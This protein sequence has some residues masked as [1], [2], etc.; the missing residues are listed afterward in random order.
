[1]IRLLIFALLPILAGCA[2]VRTAPVEMDV[3]NA[4]GVTYF[5]PK[6]DILMT[7][8]RTPLVKEEVEKSIKKIEG[9]IE[10]AKTEITAQKKLQADAVL[11]LSN[12]AISD[13]D[14]AKYTDQ[15]SFADFVI[16]K[17][18]ADNK[19]REATKAGLAASLAQH[20][21]GTCQYLY[22]VKLE[23]QPAAADTSQRFVANLTHSILRDDEQKFVVTQGGLLSS[24]D[25][26]ATD[27]TGDILVEIAG[28]I[29]AFGGGPVGVIKAA[30]FTEDNAQAVPCELTIKTLRY[31]FDPSAPEKIKAL[32]EVL[33]GGNWPFAV[34]ESGIATPPLWPSSQTTFFAAGD[35]PDGSSGKATRCLKDPIQNS[36]RYKRLCPPV[37]GLVYRTAIPVQLILWQCNGQTACQDSAGLRSNLVKVATPV[38][39]ATFLLPQVGPISYVP[40]RSSA[41]VKTVDNVVFADGMLTSW[42]ASRPSELLEVVRLPVKLLKSVISVPAEIIK[43]R[44]DYSSQTESL[45]AAYAKQLAAEQQLKKLQECIRQLEASESSDASSCFS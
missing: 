28:A 20:V 18:E 16:P 39:S 34:E 5:L 30:S 37:D 17:L 36:I 26:T 45:S 27:R 9:E 8:T 12:P 40:M 14:K 25:V 1:M 29:G 35:D 33:K 31:Q 6:R 19:A 44:V 22:D 11:R 43:L 41:F 15:K 4:E 42:T 24:A 23:L 7:A 10:T 38:Q 21:A 13:T 32:N 3:T 2:T